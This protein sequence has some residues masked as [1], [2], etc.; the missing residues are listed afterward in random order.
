MDPYAAHIQY[1]N[2]FR[3]I[4]IKGMCMQELEEETKVIE[5][6]LII[7]LYQHC[8]FLFEIR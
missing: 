5:K 4:F 7:I 8:Y 3:Q 2:K 1:A 6:Y